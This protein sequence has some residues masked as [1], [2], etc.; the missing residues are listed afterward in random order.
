[1]NRIVVREKRLL[2]QKNSMIDLLLL[3]AETA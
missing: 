2:K 3:V 1:M